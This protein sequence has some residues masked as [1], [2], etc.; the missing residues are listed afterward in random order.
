[1]NCFQPSVGPTCFVLLGKFGDIIH[2]L[3]VFKLVF[4]RDGVK[5]FVM[6]SEQF[7]SV[8]DGVSYVTPWMVPLDWKDDV[9]SARDV[10]QMHF[11]KVVVPQFWLDG[12]EN[13]MR[14]QDSVSA[15]SKLLT[16]RFGGRDTLIDETQWP[17][18]TLSMWKQS[19]FGN[20]SFQNSPVVFDRRNAEREEFLCATAGMNNGPVILYNLEG[21]SCPFPFA[22]EVL[23]AMRAEKGDAALV[24]L[25]EIK[26]E[27]IYDLLGLFDR[28]V[29]MVTVD[30][31]TLHL[32]GAG[33]IPYV[34]LLN[35]G[36][37]RAEPKGRCLLKIPY[38]EVMKRIDAIGAQV[39]FFSTSHRVKKQITW[40]RNDP[41]S[42]TKQTEWPVRV[43]TE[44]PKDAEYFN[45]GLVDI[46][47]GRW[48]VARK[49][50]HMNS[51]VA[52]KVKDDQIV[53]KGIP[54]DIAKRQQD[55]HFE[56]PRVFYHA[57]RMWLSCCNFMWGPVWTGAH[58]ILCE[59]GNDWKMIRRYDVVY[60]G[61]G[62]HVAGNRRWEK[63]WLWFF[64]DGIPHL[65]YTI[66]P[67]IVVEF[68]AKLNGVK[69]Y[70][71]DAGKKISWPW[72]EPRGG[73]PP[74][75]IG[76]EW[77]TF[78]HSSTD[79]K[80]MCSRRYHMGCYTF[81]ARPPFALK[82]YTQMPLLSGSQYDRFAHPKPAV[83]FPCGA[84]L[85]EGR[86]QISLGVNDLDCAL[87]EIPHSELE[88]LMTT[89]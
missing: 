51:L 16:L 3:P 71:T 84:L 20:Q 70:V 32:A 54:I 59:I 14:L 81:E 17:N 21:S 45:P 68:D 48:L 35:D 61:N 85:K 18:C 40:N 34:A 67:H 30:T 31:A 89:I 36:W 11:K 25:A 63:N 26:A 22:A 86:W 8:L 5:P 37:S 83:V 74:V 7:A 19:G 56:D 46:P 28:A 29:G 41:P 76:D 1:M 24:N 52:F 62:N 43:L 88:K 23:N 72:G 53:S 66:L 49:S 10:A 65:I 2:M 6:V 39:H 33:N 50:R 80:E 73:T 55:E 78:F 15:S 60:G 9:A 4:E 64:H 44:L 77:W 47:S 79:W 42:I 38:S 13:R 57:G 87:M 75:L 58:Q 27:R 82:R 12:P 69:Q